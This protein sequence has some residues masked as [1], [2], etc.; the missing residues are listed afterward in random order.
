MTAGGKM[1]AAD[2][3]AHALARLVV[4]LHS[5]NLNIGELVEGKIEV[6]DEKTPTL[7]Y[8]WENLLDDLI[9]QE[10]T[11]PRVY[12]RDAIVAYESALVHEQLAA[13]PSPPAKRPRARRAA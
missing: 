12:L 5:A 6:D 2:K 10:P 3:A 9:P 7:D 8:C 4:E 11:A 1:T 13:M